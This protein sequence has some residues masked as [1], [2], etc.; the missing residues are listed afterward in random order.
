MEHFANNMAY[1]CSEMSTREIFGIGHGRIGHGIFIADPGH[2]DSN[3]V[4]ILSRTGVTVT[5]E[6]SVVSFI[7]FHAA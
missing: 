4:C 1:K 6:I 3:D 7:G 2:N 5:A